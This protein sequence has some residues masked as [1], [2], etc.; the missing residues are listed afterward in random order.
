M[1]VVIFPWLLNM[2]AGLK[3][4]CEACKELRTG[5]EKNMVKT[6]NQNFGGGNTNWESKSLGPW[7]TSET[8]M[9][10]SIDYACKGDFKCSTFLENY[11]D[12]IEDWFK[13]G[14]DSA[15]DDQRKEFYPEI[16]VKLSKS[17]CES[18]TQFGRNCKE[19]PTGVNKEVCH[20]RGK[21]QGA[22]DRAG[23]GGCKCDLGYKGSNCDTCDGE[24]YFLSVEASEERKPECT[25]CHIGCKGC[26]GKGAEHCNECTKGWISAKEVVTKAEDSEDGEEESIMKCV[27]L[28]TGPGVGVQSETKPEGTKDTDKDTDDME[29]VIKNLGEGMGSVESATTDD[30]TQDKVSTDDAEPESK[31]PE[32]KLTVDPR[33]D[34][35]AFANVN[36]EEF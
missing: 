23:K 16:C 9:V 2:V 36:H 35:S 6:R 27:R 18:D 15:P 14:P 12:E 11:E 32:V 21:C 7:L 34:N 10:Q 29:D 30:I 20:G 31:E 26:T 5:I 8:R 28:P 24:K 3:T 17:C 25:R 19:C 1:V 22:G 33:F 13:S 4:E